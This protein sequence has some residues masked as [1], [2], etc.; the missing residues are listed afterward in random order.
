MTRSSQLTQTGMRV[1]RKRGGEEER[2][3]GK[4]LRGVEDGDEYKQNIQ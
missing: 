3:V 4:A 2:K 1:E